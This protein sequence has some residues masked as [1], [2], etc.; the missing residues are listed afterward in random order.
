MKELF[1]KTWV[2]AHNGHLN[3]RRMLEAIQNGISN[4]SLE[5]YKPK[6]ESDSEL[7]FCIIM[8]EMIYKGCKKKFIY[9]CVIF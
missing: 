4:T 9:F 2:F 7:A 1:G 3:K 6:G 5:N 8:I